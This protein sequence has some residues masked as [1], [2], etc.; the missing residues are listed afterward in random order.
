MKNHFTLLFSFL[1]I[2]L[3]VQ[4]KAQ[5]IDRIIEKT[6]D[7]L[8]GRSNFNNLN[9][10]TKDGIYFED[11]D[12]EGANETSNTAYRVKEYYIPFQGKKIVN[13][14]A[15]DTITNTSIFT[16]EQAWE[17][18]STTK[19]QENPF[20]EIL[21]VS[22]Y[23]FYT[24]LYG[25]KKYSFSNDLPIN[26]YSDDKNTVYDGYEIKGNTRCIRLLCNNINL[27]YINATTY[28]PYLYIEKFYDPKLKKELLIEYY[29]EDFRMTESGV[30]MPFKIKQ[31]TIG[32]TIPTVFKYTKIET[33]KIENVE[34]LLDTKVVA[35][36][37]KKR[38]KKSKGKKKKK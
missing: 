28:M 33:N 20:L 10:V 31:N 6:L 22:K 24:I 15:V 7:A 19:N 30:K 26:N 12:D 25:S 8:G 34:S 3:S 2:C 16:T 37:F 35:A 9:N 38:N 17:F 5:N 18:S 32:T 23:K 4:I 11:G 36:E 1:L 27:L 13:F 21:P 29:Y 14:R